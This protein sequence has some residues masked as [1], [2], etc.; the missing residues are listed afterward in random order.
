[1][2]SYN[3]YK[4]C[5]NNPRLDMKRKNYK[6]N[7]D[8]GIIRKGAKWICLINKVFHFHFFICICV[9]L[10]MM[11]FGV[12]IY[13]GEGSVNVTE[14]KTISSRTLYENKGV[15]YESNVA[16]HDNL[17]NKLYMSPNVENNGIK[18]DNV[19]GNNDLGG[20]ESHQMFKE[21]I[22]RS[23][24]LSKGNYSNFKDGFGYEYSEL[25]DSMTDEEIDKEVDELMEYTTNNKEKV[26]N[27]WWQIMRNERIKYV[28]IMKNLYKFFLKLKKKY[29]VDNTFSE[30]Q[31]NICKKAVK[32]N[33]INYEKSINTT[34]LNWCNSLLLRKD[35]YQKLIKSNRLKWKELSI[36]TE[37]AC[38]DNMVQAFEEK[39]KAESTKLDLDY[40]TEHIRK[41]NKR[42]KITKDGDGCY[43]TQSNVQ[44]NECMKTSDYIDAEDSDALVEDEVTEEENISDESVKKEEE[45]EEEEGVDIV[46]DED[47]LKDSSA[48]G[49]SS[50]S[51]YT[52]LSADSA[53]YMESDIL[54]VLDVP[55]VNGP[56]SARSVYV[57]AY[58]PEPREKLYR[59]KVRYV[60]I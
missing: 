29:N 46:E 11:V 2:V 50:T 7:V 51:K 42:K 20:M 45:K 18:E 39:V 37:K 60:T 6:Y 44:Y 5:L 19:F 21:K 32:K 58:T 16:V 27:L 40:V 55:D 30:K 22:R 17:L 34:F 1:M 59:P 9:L 23:S 25:A 12:C 52:I 57:K 38:R 24:R 15:A 33:R 28:T 26:Y 47:A 41:N 43:S 35:D 4:L 10:H 31:W 53:E 49:D 36:K 13:K 8:E 56:A 48:S 54:S 14:P 3:E